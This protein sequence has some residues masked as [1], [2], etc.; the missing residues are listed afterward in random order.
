MNA[1]AWFMEPR[2]FSCSLHW[3]GLTAERMSATLARASD[4]LVNV[5]FFSVGCIPGAPLISGGGM[6]T[7]PLG[8]LFG[9]CE[10]AGPSPPLLRRVAFF[11]MV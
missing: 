1:T 2:P 5:V 9:W 10:A 4:V 8:G 7:S 6:A 3:C 11:E